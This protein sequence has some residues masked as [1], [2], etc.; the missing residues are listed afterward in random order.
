M[1]VLSNV[2]FLCYWKRRTN[3][4]FQIPD[5]VKF[6]F[7]SQEIKH[8]RSYLDWQESYQ[9]WLKNNSESAELM[10][11]FLNPINQKQ[12]YDVLS[13]L[14]VAKNKPTRSQSSQCLQ[15]IANLTSL[16]L[17]PLIGRLK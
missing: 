3:H 12:L 7:E 13:N 15:I 10:S 17:V 6:F 14:D 4:P 5:S 9:S 1:H 2:G 16:F 11:N 8:R